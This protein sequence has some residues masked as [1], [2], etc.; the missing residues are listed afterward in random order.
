M[1]KTESIQRREKREGFGEEREE[2]SEQETAIKAGTVKA[3]PIYHALHPPLAKPSTRKGKLTA[4]AKVSNKASTPRTCSPPPP[5]AH[6]PAP[7]SARRRLGE[8]GCPGRAGPGRA[9]LRN[10]ATIPEK[11]G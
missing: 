9:L 10:E 5:A 8:L 2:R 7:T 3:V 11:R 1:S 4:A 6:R